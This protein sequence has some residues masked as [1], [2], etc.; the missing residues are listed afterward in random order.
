MVFTPQPVSLA[1]PKSIT[2]T[3]SAA[4]DEEV[5]GLDVA[6]DDAVRV[7]RGEALARLP[8][9]AEQALKRGSAAARVLNLPQ[10][11]PLDELEEQPHAVVLDPGVIDPEHVDV[12]D[13]GERLALLR[14]PSLKLGGE[15]GRASSTLSARRT[16]AGSRTSYTSAKPPEPTSLTISQ[17]AHVE[18]GFSMSIGRLQDAQAPPWRGTALQGGGVVCEGLGTYEARRCA[19]CSFSHPRAT[20]VALLRMAPR[21]T[22]SAASRS[23]VAT[24]AMSVALTP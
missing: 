3:T 12:L 15:A 11:G 17:P 14:E 13:H 21:S 22:L 7:R 5:L 9:P 6:V 18:P 8:R 19:A 16:P 24:T 2:F 20:D 10:A 23:V 1:R 4:R